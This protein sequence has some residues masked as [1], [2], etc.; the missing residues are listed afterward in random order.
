MRYEILKARETPDHSM[1]GVY[2]LNVKLNT[3]EADAAKILKRTS[4][5]TQS[6]TVP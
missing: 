2:N 6:S 1:T 5:V 3:N 4:S